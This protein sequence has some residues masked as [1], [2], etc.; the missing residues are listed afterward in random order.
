MTTVDPKSVQAAFD[1][2]VEAFPFG[3]Y[4]SGIGVDAY[5]TIADVVR[6]YLDV[7][8]TILDFGAG[9]CDTAALLQ[10]LGYRCFACDDL[11]DDWHGI[12]QNRQKILKFAAEQGVLF[13]HMKEPRLPDSYAPQFFDMAMLHAVIEHLHDS[14]R[15]LLNDILQVVRSGGLLFLTVPNAANLRKRLDVLRGRTSLPRFDSYYW[16]PGPWRGHVREYVKG[17]LALLSEYLG[18]ECLELRACDQMLEIVPHGIK[19]MYILLTKLFPG[20]KDSWLLVARKPDGWMPRRSL[21]PQEW[22]KIRSKYISR[23]AIGDWLH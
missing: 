5:R 10:R 15:E 9:P 23:S 7:G 20:L 13:E 1:E 2:V 4:V 12:G 19:R 22:W 16:N 3:G 17:D 21:P 18:L 6:R 8:A 11:D 14:P